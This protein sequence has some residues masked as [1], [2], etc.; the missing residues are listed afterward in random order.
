ME[1]VQIQ[2][3]ENRVSF[4]L[5]LKPS[6]SLLHAAASLCRVRPSFSLSIEPVID[7]TGYGHLSYNL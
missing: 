5:K 7:R 1:S 3:K 4:S 6:L 2:E